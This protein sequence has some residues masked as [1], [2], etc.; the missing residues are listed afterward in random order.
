MNGLEWNDLR[1]VLAIGRAGSLAGAARELKNDHSTIFR[2]LNSIE[3]RVGV[4]FFDR[5]NGRYEMTEAG[6]AALKVAKSFESDVLDLDRELLGRDAR[7]QGNIRISA[8]EG[9]AV[10]SLPKV[11]AGFRRQHPEVTL[12]LMSEFGA[13][14]L[15]RREADIALRI[16]K[17]PPD[18]NLGRC[19]CDF[20]FSAYASPAYL[21]KSGSRPL[22]DH[23][24]VVFEPT[25][26]WT[27]PL[28]F[29]SNDVRESRTVL[30]TDSV[31]S[32]VAAAREGIGALVISSFLA[33]ADPRL[34]RIAGPFNEITLQLWVL[35]HPDLRNTT[36]VTALMHHIVREL[37]R[38]KALFEGRAYQLEYQ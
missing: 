16:T 10:V 1:L 11:L 36:R 29:P 2:K 14:D 35:M 15:N 6:E 26:S 24:W 38:E 21:E 18:N 30:S 8:P 22:I 33:D 17:T 3:K 12:E 4:R 19:I 34:T 27:T 9:P 5:L 23:D 20:T 28:I 7:L 13:A 31:H 25:V 32:A 37:R